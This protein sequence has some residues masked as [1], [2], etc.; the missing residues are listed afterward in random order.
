MSTGSYDALL[1]PRSVAIVGASSDP[2]RI[3]GRLIA[4][5]LQAGYAGKIYPVNPGRPEIQGL[6]AYKSVAAIDGKVDCALI[7]LPTD[8]VMPALRE[9]A[10]KGVGV[11]VLFSAGF[12]EVGGKGVEL[13]NEMTALSRRSGMRLLGPNC[14][15]LYNVAHRFY[16]TFTAAYQATWNPGRNVA[17]I[18][19]SGGYGGQF[20]LTAQRRGLAVGHW[21]TTGNEADLEFGELLGALAEQPEVNVIVGYVEDIRSRETFIRGLEAAHRNRKPVIILKVGRSVRGAEAAASHTASLA[22]ADDVYTSIFGEYGVHRAYSTEEV[23]DVAYGAVRGVFPARNS[24]CVV[25][26]T[27]GVGVQIAD[28]AEDESVAMPVVPEPAFSAI[29]KVIP[30]GSARNPI[31]VTGQLANEP[32]LLGDCSRLALRTGAYDTLFAILAANAQREELAMKLLATMKEVKAEFPNA[33]IG[34]SLLAKPEIEQLFDNAGF[35]LI[36]E[37]QRMVRVVAALH[38]FATAFGRK[39]PDRLTPV[40]D[41]ALPRMTSGQRFNEAE[42]KALVAKI[43]IPAPPEKIAQSAD[44]AAAAATA[45]G[46]PVALKVVS[47]DILHKTEVGGVALGLASAE[48]VAAAQRKM[49]ASVAEHAPKAKVEGYLVSKMIVGGVECIL[50]VHRDPL[51]GPVVMFGLGGVTVELFKDVMVRLA[52]VTEEQALEMISGIKGHPLLDGY[53][54]KPKADVKALAKA[55]AAVSR[56]AAAN[57]DAK[58]IEINPLVAMPEG[59][60]V[61]AL[62]AVIETL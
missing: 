59:Q 44:V 29:Q 40:T 6:P 19:Q 36:E 17:L 18:S 51:F 13:Q 27:G 25:T 47:A 58:T 2:A 61:Y 11:A 8:G 30:L 23:L 24:M 31:D 10:D 9:C 28:F 14:L 48:A 57:P 1:A 41:A 42:A 56:L 52:P 3:G 20:V 55:V 37:P 39:L 32:N 50:G 46:F 7:A 5:L 35:M 22:G 53:R 49:A 33:L 43:G 16:L 26:P 12:A 60:G 62:D 45:M 4:R 34:L 15:G 21:L 38:G 54:G